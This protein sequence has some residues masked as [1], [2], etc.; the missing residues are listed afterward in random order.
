MAKTVAREHEKNR[1]EHRAEEEWKRIQSRENEIR[2]RINSL[3]DSKRN[4]VLR[5]AEPSI[6]KNKTVIDVLMREV[7]DIENEIA[8]K[9]EELNTIMSTPKKS[10]QSP[11]G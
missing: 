9:V 1:L 6:A 3:R 10:N 8:E 2:A 7:K 5:I 4:M 11:Q